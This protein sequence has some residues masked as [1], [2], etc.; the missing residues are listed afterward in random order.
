MIVTGFLH[1]RLL[2]LFVTVGFRA[3]AIEKFKAANKGQP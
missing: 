1:F 3:S 2:R